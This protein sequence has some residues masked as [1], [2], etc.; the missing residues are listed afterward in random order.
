MKHRSQV[1]NAMQKRD[2]KQLWSGLNNGSV[3]KPPVH[4]N[5]VEIYS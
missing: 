2:H 5:N 1:M 4:I 3:I